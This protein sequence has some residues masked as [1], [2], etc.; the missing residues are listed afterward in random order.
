VRSTTYLG[1]GMLAFVFAGLAFLLIQS[2]AVEE[3]EAKRTGENVVRLFAQSISRVLT[4]A[5]NTLL[6]LRAIYESHP[7][8]TAFVL[9][10]TGPEFKNDLKFQYSLIGPD[11]I[12]RASTYGPSS[13]GF[14]LS[15]QPHFMT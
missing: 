8:E 2:R 5:D 1:L 3:D 6:L 12:V 13:I 11:G 9:W 7:D 14:D 4:D 10:P 15:D